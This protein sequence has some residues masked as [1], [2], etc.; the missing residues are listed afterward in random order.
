MKSQPKDWAFLAVILLLLA[1]LL[2]AEFCSKPEPLEVVR[3]RSVDLDS[4][5]TVWGPD[6]DSVVSPIPPFVEQVPRVIAL[7][8]TAAV[9]SLI[10]VF[11]AQRL[12]YSALVSR[13]EA[14][15][16]ERE[17]AQ[18]R[19]QDSLD[20]L[21]LLERV[22]VY[23]DS[24]VTPSYFHRWKIE[25][26]GP[27]R[28]YAYTVI[29]LCP[30]PVL[31]TRKNNRAFVGFGGQAQAGALRQVYVAGYGYKWAWAQVGYLPPVRSLSLGGAAQVAA[32]VSVSF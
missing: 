16:R 30:D 19:L 13:L 14:A 25:A 10:R 6:P 27:L 12:Y 18:G 17:E 8:D 2:R 24:A 9:D 7:R 11:A 29:P 3:W 26:E 28:S 15:V 23:Q 1:L 31:P 22:S 32:G 20:R 5:K 21:V 4:L